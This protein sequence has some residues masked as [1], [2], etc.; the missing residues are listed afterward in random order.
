MPQS[1]D[2]VA[3]I[4]TC[5]EEIADWKTLQYEIMF[6]YCRFQIIY[7]DA[8]ERYSIGYSIGQPA[9]NHWCLYRNNIMS[10]LRK[11]GGVERRP[12]QNWALGSQLPKTPTFLH[13]TTLSWE[14]HNVE[15]HV[16]IWQYFQIV[17]SFIRTHIMKES[18]R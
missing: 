2:F 3:V 10:N 15:Q 16:R 5:Y 18:T 14:C 9:T 1:H 6:G 7:L 13:W 12:T 11:S 4:W 8:K 17:H